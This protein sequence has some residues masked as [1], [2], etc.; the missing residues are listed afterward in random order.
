MHFGIAKLENPI[1]HYDW[2]SREFIARLQA[3]S[4]PSE[5]PEA[6]LWIGAHPRAPSR[7]IGAIEESLPNCI[8]RAPELA[9]GERSIERFGPTLPFL[10]KLLAAA[11]PLSIQVHPDAISARRGFEAEERRG[12]AP[13]ASEFK[14]EENLDWHDPWLKSQD[15]E[16][17]NLN[18][19]SGLYW[20][21]EETGD[22]FRKTTDA[23]IEYSKTAPPRG[24][25][26]DGRGALIK[27][28]T[29]THAGYL[30]DWI[31]FRLSKNE[32]PFLMLDPFVSYKSEIRDY[33]RSMDLLP[34][35]EEE[36]S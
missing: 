23:A 11:S 12:V 5:L 6:E 33:L 10:V 8:R 4:T 28:L 2:G 22:A 18:R 7:L 17:H 30:I 36:T 13:D 19:Q 27:A 21:L 1:R 32:E 34:R 16:Y 3:R 26:A 35:S 25:R 24:T 20:G 15:L 31:G 14:K 9:L 29:G